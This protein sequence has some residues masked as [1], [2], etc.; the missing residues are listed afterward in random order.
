MAAHS[1]SQNNEDDEP[2]RRIEDGPIAVPLTL[3]ERGPGTWRTEAAAGA[4]ASIVVLAVVLTVGMVGFAP[5]GPEAAALGVAASFVTAVVG[6]LVYALFGSGGMPTAGPSSATAIVFGASLIPLIGAAAPHGHEALAPVLAAGGAMVAL[7]GLLQVAIARLGLGELVQFVP[8]PVLAGFMNG[9]AVLIVV[10]QWPM[11]LG[12]EGPGAPPQLAALG[13][14]LVSAAVAWLIVWRWP[15]SPGQLIGLC[16]GLALYAFLHRA[17][18]TLPLGAVVGSLPA[19]LPRPELPLQLARPEIAG[20][21]RQHALD[22]ATGASV[23]ALIGSLES[24]LSG[25]AVDQQL[26]ARHDPTRTLTVLGAANL[27]VGLF[28]GLPVVMLRARA[29]ATLHAGG[30]GRRAAI[31]GA[32]TF[33]VIFL[34]F[35]EWIA[36]LPK[37]V[38]AG[39]MLTVA[40][41]LVDRWTR[42]LV[43]QWRA[44]ERSADAWQA[45]AIVLGVCAMTVWKGFEVGVAVGVLAALL[46]F[47]R[48]LHRSLVRV[49]T[50][51][52]QLPSRRIYPSALEAQLTAKRASVAVMQLEGP[53]FF[54]NAGRLAREAEATMASASHLVFDL[55]GVTTI[56]ASGA[57]LLQRLSQQGRR[58]GVAVLL[59]GLGE[60]HPHGQRLRAFGCFRESPRTD[61]FAD[62]DRAVEAAE[63]QLL[64]A[65]G[66]GAVAL[67]VPVEHSSLFRDLPAGSSEALLARLE[68]C[69]IAAGEILFRQ[70]DH[71]DGLYVVTSGSISIVAGQGAEHERRRYAS[72]SAGHM[73]GETALL[74]GGGRS[75]T[76]TADVDSVLYRLGADALSALEREDPDLARRVH[77]N[78]ATHLS[79]RLRR[80]TAL[81]PGDRPDPRNAGGA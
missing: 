32:L 68:R 35:R 18:P 23:L 76:A 19:E 26:G 54:G 42:Q 12:L 3:P 51:A 70:G 49:R 62:L 10:A 22:I 21:L 28:G 75:A 38:L 8:Q 27:L 17:W 67:D 73:F 69:P 81:A 65:E 71:A 44:G 41:A 11:L 13:L 43:D 45:L 58:S 39:I 57:T 33:A 16:L 79:D 74:D 64:G 15:G 60:A 24:V 29:V 37:A 5:L 78:I 53:L 50:T 63:W 61:W 6:G 31:A 40:V 20:F 55:R 77:R 7:M 34:L 36:M 9:V 80:A 4:A 25:L 48:S 30:R 46:V 59:A 52:A 66:A 1:T 2:L 56:D 14:G 72:Y 47:V